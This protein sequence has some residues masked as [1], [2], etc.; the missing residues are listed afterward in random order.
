MKK[1][2]VAIIYAIFILIFLTSCTAYEYP[3]GDTYQ[4]NEPYL[5]LQLNDQQKT[6]Y[7]E[8]N[9]KTIKVIVNIDIGGNFF[10]KEYAGALYVSDADTVLNLLH[11]DIIVKGKAIPNNKKGLLYLYPDTEEYPDF[12][13]MYVLQK[14]E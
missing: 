2:T 8:Y 5:Y 11:G 14:V 4:C 13:E 10:I 7:M 3:D 6:S 12:K 1:I 9:N